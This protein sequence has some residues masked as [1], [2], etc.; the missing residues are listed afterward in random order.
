[1]STRGRPRAFDKDKALHQ[2]ML[3]FWAHGYE[4]ASLGML[5]EAMGINR[6]SLYSSFGCKE[7]L[8]RQVIA[9]YL[10]TVGVNIIERME[11]APSAREGI[12]NVLRINAEI[13]A[14]S[15]CPTGCLVVTS[16]IIAAPDND[17]ICDFL[18][19][20]RKLG[21]DAFQRRIERDIEAGQLPPTLDARALANF[22]T[23]LLQGLS[24]RARDGAKMEDFMSIIDTAMSL[25]DT[26]TPGHESRL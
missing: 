7:E 25:W 19:Q 1:M 10:N 17:A 16:S 21:F 4:G 11:N 15:D 26:L 20:Q 18:S 5:T 8:F 3:V 12:Y 2:A 6:P 24:L 14:R 13:Y 9:Y 23:T 22:Y